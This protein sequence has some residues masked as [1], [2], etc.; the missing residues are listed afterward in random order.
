MDNTVVVW[1][2]IL[3]PYFCLFVTLFGSFNINF[4]VKFNI[5]F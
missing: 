4:D 1:L 5:G 3:G 2:H